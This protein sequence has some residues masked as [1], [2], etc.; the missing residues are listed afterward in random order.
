MAM[1]VCTPPRKTLDVCLSYTSVALTVY[2]VLLKLAT[3]RG[4]QYDTHTHTHILIITIIV[5]ITFIIVD[6][7]S[8]IPS[9][10]KLFLIESL[11][12]AQ[13]KKSQRDALSVISLSLYEAPAKVSLGR[14]F[15]L[16]F[17]H[18]GLGFIFPAIL[19]LPLTLTHAHS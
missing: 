2:S 9:P 19:S 1:P 13:I 5:I 16:N 10:V 6:R 18:L 17:T 12:P 15:F 3:N 11:R 4:M 14:L 8:S 7:G